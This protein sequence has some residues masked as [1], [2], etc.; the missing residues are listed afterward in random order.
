MF[1]NSEESIALPQPVKCHCG[2][3]YLLPILQPITGRKT[4]M[5]GPVEVLGGKYQVIWE[6]SSCRIVIKGDGAPSKE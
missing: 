1:N 5:Y 6:C 3:G 4:S 2:K